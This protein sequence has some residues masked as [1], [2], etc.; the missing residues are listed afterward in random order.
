MQQPDGTDRFFCL[1]RALRRDETPI[2]P[3][4]EQRIPDPHDS[5]DHVNPSRHQV[6]YFPCGSAHFLPF[7]IFTKLRPRNSSAVRPVIFNASCSVIAPELIPRRK[8]LRRPCP[9]AASSKTS[10]TSV[11]C[12]ALPTK[13]LSRTPAAS[14]PSRKKL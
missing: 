8:K 12:A 9:V 11:A 13:F 1:R 10:P 7:M 3:V 2:E 4:E 5:R 6:E 14:I